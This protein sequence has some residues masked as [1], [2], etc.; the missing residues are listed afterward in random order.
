[1]PS[2]NSIFTELVSTTFR[3][4]KKEIADNVSKNNALLRRLMKKDKIRL[5]DGGSSIVCPLDYAEN[6]TL[7]SVTK[8]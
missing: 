1:M 6:Q 4:H 3:N 8:H 5:E 2:P 7:R